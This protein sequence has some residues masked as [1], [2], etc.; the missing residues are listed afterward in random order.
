MK[1]LLFSFLSLSAFAYQIE[2]K[3]SYPHG[4]YKFAHTV[5][6]SPRES[7][8]LYDLAKDKKF[9]ETFTPSDIADLKEV[10]FYLTKS[11]ELG[12]EASRNFSLDDFYIIKSIQARDLED[13]KERTL[14]ILPLP[15]EEKLYLLLAKMEPF[16]KK[17]IWN[18]SLA[19]LLSKKK[20]YDELSQKIGLYDFFE[21]LKLTYQ[22]AWPASQQFYVGLAPIPAKEGHSTASSIGIVESV[23]VLTQELDDSGRFGVIIHE[24]AHSLYK[25]QTTATRERW[26]EWITKNSPNQNVSRLFLAN[27][28][29]IFATIIGNGYAFELLEGKID[30]TDWYNDEII[31]TLA[32]LLYEDFKEYLI[33]KKPLD[34]NFFKHALIKIN[35][36]APKLQNLNELYLK[37]IALASNLEKDSTKNSR[38]SFRNIFHS[39]SIYGHITIQGEY[40]L[41]LD[42]YLKE[43]HSPVLVM[44]N[45]NE[46]LKISKKLN[47]KNKKALKTF[48][49]SNNKSLVLKNNSDAY[50]F[51][52]AKNINELSNELETLKK[53]KYIK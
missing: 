51:F 47:S 37:E 14:G 45:K 28:N 36:E 33:N 27:Y 19:D 43:F 7:Q 30:Q 20:K 29:E 53:Q 9:F 49:K 40:L 2:Y 48:I 41:K 39:S 10:L 44:N 32:K 52:Y 25:E 1:Y 50:F 38:D 8:T 13:L 24:M 46:F 35:K 22:S 23:G 11:H 31:N 26:T 42:E 17:E 12:Y 15:L 6:G 21:T 16:Y 5:A 34:E 18:D 4:L 3:I